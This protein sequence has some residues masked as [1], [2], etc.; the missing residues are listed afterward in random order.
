MPEMHLRQP[1]FACSAWDQFLKIKKLEKKIKKQ[2]IQDIITTTNQT[3]PA[4]RNIWIL[5][6][7]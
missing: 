2:R 5:D 1:K 7:I 4:F 6:G 3:K